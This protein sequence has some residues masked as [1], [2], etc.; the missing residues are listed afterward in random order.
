MGVDR[1]SEHQPD[2]EEAVYDEDITG[3]FDGHRVFHKIHH[4]LQDSPLIPG[5]VKEH[6]RY[7]RM[8]EGCRLY[9]L[10]GK[11]VAVPKCHV[12]HKQDGLK[13]RIDAVVCG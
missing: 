5:V 9:S 3:W 8:V 4:N 12:N 11:C 2:D 13:V 7:P 6:M 10:P 1:N